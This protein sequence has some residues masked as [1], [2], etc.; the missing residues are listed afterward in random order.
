MVWTWLYIAWE[1][2]SISNP[3]TRGTAQN[4]NQPTRATIRCFVFL[5]SDEVLARSLLF[6]RLV[7]VAAAA[8]DVFR[9]ETWIFPVSVCVYAAAADG[10]CF[11]LVF[12]SPYV[13][14]LLLTPPLSSLAKTD[15]CKDSF[16]FFSSL[17][18]QPANVKNYI[19]WLVDDSA[20]A[21]IGFSIILF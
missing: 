2:Q 7:L 16:S 14:C 20:A 9:L 19:S 13:V 10:S 11:F 4:S 8:W 18:G 15:F 5:S 3:T 1:F 17:S 6:C 12:P 21:V